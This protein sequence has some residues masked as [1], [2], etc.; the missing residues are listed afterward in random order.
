MGKVILT[1]MCMIYNKKNHNVLDQN[2]IKRTLLSHKILISYQ[3]EVSLC[4]KIAT[5]IQPL[6]LGINFFGG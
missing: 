6:H 1:N 4:L 3:K 2:R 5:E